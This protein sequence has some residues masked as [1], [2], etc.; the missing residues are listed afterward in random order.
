MVGPQGSHR[1][2]PSAPYSI[3]RGPLSAVVRAHSSP[4]VPCTTSDA[5]Y[6]YTSMLMHMCEHVYI[7]REKE[8][9][10]ERADASALSLELF[11]ASP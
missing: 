5:P 11:P 2:M 9:E 4:L 6:P 8:R 10:R 1:D 3:V 7:H